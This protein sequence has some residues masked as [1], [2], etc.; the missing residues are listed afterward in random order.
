MGTKPVRFLHV[1]GPIDIAHAAHANEAQ[2][3]PVTDLLHSLNEPFR[4][5]PA[6]DL[7]QS[8]YQVSIR[9]LYLL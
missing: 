2:Q 5:L 6:T 3:L 8:R 9:K 7:L 4:T 1:L